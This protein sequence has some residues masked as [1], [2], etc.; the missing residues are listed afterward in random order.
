MHGLSIFDDLTFLN[1]GK[2]FIW[3]SEKD[4]Y[5]HIYLH[6]YS[7]KQLNQLTKGSWEVDNVLFADEEKVVFT[8]NERGIRYSDLYQVKTDGSGFSRITDKPGVHSVTLS[9]GGK[10]YIDRYSNSTTPTS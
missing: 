10:Y 7:G 8:A 9:S 3:T 6:D 1:D 2:R 4:G 5:K